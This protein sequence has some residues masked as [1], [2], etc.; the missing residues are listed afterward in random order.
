MHDRRPTTSRVRAFVVGTAV[1]MA[2]A[3]CAD[4]STPAETSAPRTTPTPTLTPEVSESPGLTGELTVSAAVTLQGAFDQILADFGDEFPGVTVEPPVYGASPALATQLV[5]GGASDVFAAADEASMA[6]VAGA[7]L[8][9]GSAT[10]FATDALV[11]V[12][13]AGNPKNL[14]SLHDLGVLSDSGGKVV[15]CAATEPCGS[16]AH[17]VLDTSGVGVRASSNEPDVQAVLAKV[18]SGEAD[19]GLVYRGALQGAGDAVAGVEFAEST[20]AVVRYPIAV[21]TEPTPRTHSS[22]VAQAFVDYVLGP[23]GQAILAANGFGAP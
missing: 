16:A 8:V 21:L 5:A 19:A 17:K 23:Q 4:P 14:Q 3:A 2:L 13:P 11:I 22:E 12:V 9:D 20:A 6:T 10:I 15:F 1:L 7:G 18:Q